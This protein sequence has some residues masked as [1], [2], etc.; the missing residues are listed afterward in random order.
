MGNLPIYIVNKCL[1]V[2]WAKKIKKQYVFFD[3]LNVIKNLF[4][5]TSQAF[6]NAT[7]EIDIL[8]FLF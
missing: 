8:K 2:T 4:N 5:S 6:K 7:F 3:F 1:R